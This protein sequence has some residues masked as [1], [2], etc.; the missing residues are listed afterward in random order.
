MLGVLLNQKIS[1]LLAIVLI[2]GRVIGHE[3][4]VEVVIASHSNKEYGS[5]QCLGQ[6]HST[7]VA[8]Y[9]IKCV[10]KIL[11]LLVKWYPAHL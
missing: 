11:N 1:V 5:A 2:P 3:V 7:Q 10:L 9:L 8:C 4:I 6:F